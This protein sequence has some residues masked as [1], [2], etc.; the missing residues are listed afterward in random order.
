[1]SAELIDNLAALFEVCD[2]EYAAA[3]AAIAARG[4][5]S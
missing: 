1:M 4:G 3:R 2:Q 5:A